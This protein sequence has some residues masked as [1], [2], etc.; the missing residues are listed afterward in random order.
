MLKNEAFDHIAKLNLDTVRFTKFYAL[1]A[2]IK[3]LN[4]RT[5]IEMSQSI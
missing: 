5:E 2:E 3:N 4:F 1:I